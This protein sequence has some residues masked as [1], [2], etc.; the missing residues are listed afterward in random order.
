LLKSARGIRRTHDA[1]NYPE[2]DNKSGIKFSIA[3]D[4]IP[5]TVG[6]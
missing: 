5:S 6:V 3:H 1:E 4:K 2:R